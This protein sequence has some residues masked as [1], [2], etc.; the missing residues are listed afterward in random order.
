MP[1]GTG[2]YAFSPKS[3]YSLQGKYQLTRNT[4]FKYLVQLPS[5]NHFLGAK[6]DGIFYV[7]KVSK[8]SVQD[9]YSNEINI[10]F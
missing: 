4:P 5:S 1:N 2:G 10:D 7:F 8:T 6:G 9:F 3:T